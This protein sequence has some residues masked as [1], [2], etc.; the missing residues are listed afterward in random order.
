MIWLTQYKQWHNTFLS[1]YAFFPLLSLLIIFT[2][3]NAWRGLTVWHRLIYLA[4][5]H[6]D[7]F[8]ICFMKWFDWQNI[9]NEILVYPFECA[10]LIQ[11]KSICMSLWSSKTVWNGFYVID[12]FQEIKLNRFVT[13]GT[14]FYTV[15]IQYKNLFQNGGYL[16][17]F[18]PG[19]S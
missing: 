2:F 16:A 10:I 11:R 18:Q 12:I 13:R 1:F 6:K 3:I 15:S 14:V 7:T 5:K 9:N 17:K 4:K 8:N 19:G